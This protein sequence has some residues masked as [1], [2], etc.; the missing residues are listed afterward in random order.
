MYSSAYFSIRVENQ[1]V[2]YVR[3]ALAFASLE[4][5]ESEMNQVHRAMATLQRAKMGLLCD[6]RQVV[7]RNDP[8]FEVVFKKHRQ[9]LQQ[10]FFRVAV[11]VSSPTGMLHIQRLANEDGD[12]HLRAFTDVDKAHSWLLHALPTL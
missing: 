5:I 6:L 9:T 10:G 7:G 8:E 12:R 3:S 1:V 11:L 2:E 4:E